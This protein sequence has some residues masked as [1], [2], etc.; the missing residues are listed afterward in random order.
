LAVAFDVHF[1][2]DGV[3][4]QA[5]NRRERHRGIREDTGPLAEGSVRGDQQAAAFISSGNQ[6]EQHAGL[7]LIAIDV[8]EVIEN[9]QLILCS[10]AK[11]GE[12]GD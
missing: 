3:M 12:T 2:D 6:F 10:V 11:N 1:E 8:A 5:V 4:H 9:D 7:R